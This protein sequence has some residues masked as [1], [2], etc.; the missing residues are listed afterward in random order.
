MT[1]IEG[2]RQK[3]MNIYLDTKKSGVETQLIIEKK[4]LKYSKHL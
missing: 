4:R 3:V 2:V 1:S